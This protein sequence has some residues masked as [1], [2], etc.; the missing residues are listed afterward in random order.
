MALT[1]FKLSG[2]HPRSRGENQIHGP[3]GEG[4]GWLIPAHAGKTM[5]SVAARATAR[6]HPRSRGENDLPGFVD[7]DDGGSSP[8]TRGKRGCFGVR[9]SMR[10]LIPAHAGKTAKGLDATLVEGAHPRSRGENHGVQSRVVN[11]TG[12]SPLTRGKLNVAQLLA[13]GIGLIPAHAGKTFSR[14]AGGH[15]TPA[16]PRSRGENGYLSV[17]R[18][19]G[20]GSSPLTRGKLR[21]SQSDR[22]S[23][24]LIPAHAGK[25]CS[26][27]C[28]R[29]ASRAHPRSRGEN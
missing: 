20:L 24:G 29:A 10:R 6:A 28:P 17:F 18:V 5:P 21:S 15:H 19:T 27:S 9:R 13:D 11:Q 7:A 3:V 23:G 1:Q 4:F 16:H 14:R 8:L 2:A 25:T 26:W 12:S 22:L